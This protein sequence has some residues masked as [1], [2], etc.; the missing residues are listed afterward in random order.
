MLKWLSARIVLKHSTVR[1]SLRSLAWLAAELVPVLLCA[2]VV[3]VYR[4]LHLEPIEVGGDALKVWEFARSLSFGEPIPEKLNHHTSRFGLV[5]PSLLAQKWAGSQ[6]TSYYLAPVAS[7]VLLHVLVYLV[8]KRLSGAMAGAMGV[9][10]LLFFEPMTRASSQILPE[11]FGPTYIMAATYF[12]LLSGDV[13]TALGRTLA[14]CAACLAIFFAYGSKLVY[15]Y[16]A[17]GLAALL[18]FGGSQVQAQ[19][20]SSGTP[21]RSGPVARVWTWCR[22]H[23][24]VLPGALAGGVLLL[25]ALETLFLGTATSS[26]NRLSVVTGSHWIQ[27]DPRLL[28]QGQEFFAL[29]QRAPQV[30]E[31]ALAAGAVSAAGVAAFAI[32]RRARLFALMLFIY[33][34]LQTFIVRSIDPLIP[35]LEP[36]PRYLL[37]MAAPLAVLIGVFAQEVL[38]ALIAQGQVLFTA[39]PWSNSVGRVVSLGCATFILWL[40]VNELK[41]DWD[42]GWGRRDSWHRSQRMAEQLTEAFAAGLPIVAPSKGGKPAWAAV[43]VLIDP[44]LL[45][46]D[47]RVLPERAFKRKYGKGRYVARA[48]AGKSLPTSRLDRVVRERVRK[49]KCHVLAR[50]GGRFMQ[51]QVRNKPDCESLEETFQRDPKAGSKPPAKKRK[52]KPR[53]KPSAGGR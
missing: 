43:A 42:E 52:K 48:V 36:H 40:P 8:G 35:W 27:T 1:T 49:R 46:R 45:M 18:W 47:G 41:K 24:L 21:A 23:R 2:L 44:Q 3:V 20:R 10:A 6:A 16:Y 28:K 37:A 51:I 38:K 17:P 14:L 34:L 4:L 25:L 12:V 22:K 39:S 5:I 9:L 31:Q 7:S 11:T 29:Y 32:E 33:F 30:W 26:G 50:Q 13:K 53:K 19:T 15:L